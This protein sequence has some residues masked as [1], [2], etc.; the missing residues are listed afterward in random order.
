MNRKGSPTNGPKK[1]EIDDNTQSRNPRDEI[2]TLYVS[3]KGKGRGLASIGN[4]T[5]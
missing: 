3:R 2:D 5:H 4:V 1:K